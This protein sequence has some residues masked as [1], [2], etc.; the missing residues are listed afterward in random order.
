MKKIESFFEKSELSNFTL[1][2]NLIGL[3]CRGFRDETE[4]FVEIRAGTL[5][6]LQLHYKQICFLCVITIGHKQ[7]RSTL[8]TSREVFQKHIS[9]SV[10][11]FLNLS[12]PVPYLMSRYLFY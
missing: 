1:S 4:N 7:T 3:F 10:I 8:K 9:L 6:T 11:I 2:V 12:P 5:S